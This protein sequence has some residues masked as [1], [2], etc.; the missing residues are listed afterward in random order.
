MD[1]YYNTA[2]R[3]YKSS[4]ILHNNQEFHNSCYL[5]G[6]IIECYAK[7]IIGV[8]YGF[9]I[10]DLKDFGHD[11]KRM[12]RE[13]QYIISHSSIS[14]YM[15][16]MPVAFSKSLSG[17]AKWDPFKRYSDTGNEWSETDSNDYQNEIIFAMQKITQMRL[18]GHNLI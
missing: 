18:D 15:L 16:D 9:N 4:Q 5:G 3:M 12:N 14:S 6:Y 2:N 13:F 17:N 8:S 10:P 7:I 1:N 11:L